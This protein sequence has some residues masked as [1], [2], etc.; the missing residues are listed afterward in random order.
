M[1]ALFNDILFHTHITSKQRTDRRCLAPIKCR[2]AEF[3][4]NTPIGY[5]GYAYTAVMLR[6]VKQIP[7]GKAATYL[8]QRRK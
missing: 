2:Q 7:W 8:T 6:I 1:N 4:M 5:R 3:A